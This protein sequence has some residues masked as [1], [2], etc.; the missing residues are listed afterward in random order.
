[1]AGRL[2]STLIPGKY[3]ARE[4]MFMNTSGAA[5]DMIVMNHGFFQSRQEHEGHASTLQLYVE[6]SYPLGTPP[7]S[8]WILVLFRVYA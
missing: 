5:R 7:K 8:Y 3:S 2:R 4:L 1:M 6:S